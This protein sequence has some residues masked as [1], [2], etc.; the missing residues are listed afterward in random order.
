MLLYGKGS[1]GP[2]FEPRL[3]A[4]NTLSYKYEGQ[5]ALYTRL[6]IL[7]WGNIS[8]LMQTLHLVETCK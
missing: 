2:T 8:S 5:S 6:K 3:L 1:R 7:Q 4:T